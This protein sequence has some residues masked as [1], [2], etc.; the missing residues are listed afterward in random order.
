MRPGA[1]AR[2]QLFDMRRELI[3]RLDRAV[4]GGDL[5]LLGTVQLAINA[6]DGAAVGDSGETG[7]GLSLMPVGESAYAEIFEYL[8]QPGYEDVL[9]GENGEIDLKGVRLIR[10]PQ[11]DQREQ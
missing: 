3:Q 4:T 10:R 5:A 7:D 2:A 9:V 6:I 1:R 11:A 8:R